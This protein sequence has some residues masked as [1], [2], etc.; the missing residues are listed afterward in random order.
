MR[1]MSSRRVAPRLRRELVA[2]IAKIMRV[3]AREA[4]LTTPPCE[5]HPHDRLVLA[6]WNA[7]VRFER[8][9]QSSRDLCDIEIKQDFTIH[10]HTALRD[11]KTDQGQCSS[12]ITK[13]SLLMTLFADLVTFVAFPRG[14]GGGS[15]VTGYANG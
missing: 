4:G 15:Q 7:S 13:P 8:R 5:R 9:R 10:G 12:L 6:H 2:R 14:D 1:F 11:G 3:E